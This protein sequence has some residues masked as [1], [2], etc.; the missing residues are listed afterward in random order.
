MSKKQ[1]ASKPL[2]RVA[3]FRAAPYGKSVPNCSISVLTTVSAVLTQLYNDAHGERQHAF[4][5]HVSPIY[6]ELKASKD[7]LEAVRMLKAKLKKAYLEI[8]TL[9]DQI[10]GLTEK[11]END[12]LFRAVPRSFQEETLDTLAGAFKSFLKLRKNGDMDA[13]PPHTRNPEFFSEIPGRMSFEVKGSTMT[14]RC[15]NIGSGT[16]LIFQVPEHQQAL[17]RTA[18]RIKKFTLYR[19]PRKLSESGEF[20]ISVA[21]EI[22]RPA[23]SIQHPRKIAFIK[24]GSSSIGIVSPAGYEVIEFD[25]PDKFWQPK[26]ETLHSR[27]KLSQRG[28][29]SYARRTDSVRTMYD[30]QSGQS[31]LNQR[32]IA[33]R[34]IRKHGIHFVIDEVVVRSKKGKLAD[35]S[36]AERG[37]V[38]GLNW[39][40]QNTGSFA[41]FVSHLEEKVKEKGGSVTKVKLSLDSAPARI[42]KRAKINLALKLREQYLASLEVGVVV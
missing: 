21:Y 40:A 8:P 41:R 25:R 1:D 4:E 42:G 30:K 7:N 32:E 11:R 2:Y 20:W 36:K 5:T 12:P 39:S 22:E 33:Q 28:S 29:R 34:L 13:R 16:P 38:L 18:K 27:I 6:E 35:G 26:I 14:I 24:S 37:G 15:P 10:N 9:F 31:K 23:L 19:E 3:K 17:F